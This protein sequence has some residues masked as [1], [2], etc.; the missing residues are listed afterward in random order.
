[1]TSMVHHR[2]FAFGILLALA[3]AFIPAPRSQA[4]R[5]TFKEYVD[6]LGNLSVKSLYQDRAGFLWV[7]TQGGLFRYDGSRFDEFGPAQGFTAPMVED[8]REDA[9]GR[10]WVASPNG[11]FVG[12]AGHF[13]PVLQQGKP[14]SIRVGSRIAALPDGSVLV[15]SDRGLF[16]PILPS[17]TKTWQLRPALPASIAD[18]D[19][20]RTFGLTVTPAGAIW[21][22]C[23]TS[24]CRYNNGSLKKWAEKDGLAK[25]PWE[26]L[27]VDHS[28]Q[29]WA[30]GRSHIAVFNPASNRFEPRDI[31]NASQNLDYRTLAL[32]AQ[33]RVLAPSSDALARFEN[34]Q[35]RIF[36]EK[37]GLSG[38]MLTAAF[39]DRE[40]S[41]W[42]GVLGRGLARWLGYGQWEHWTKAE[43]LKSNI[44]WRVA[45]DQT[46]R[47][48]IGDEKGVS[49]IDPGS[50]EAHPWNGPA[51]S[52]STVASIAVS[53]DGYVWLGF[54]N[55]YVLRVD[56]KT[57]QVQQFL[58]GD[59]SQIMV[60]SHDRVWTATLS[61]LFVSD[62]ATSTNPRT[63]F[64]KVQAPALPSGGFE[65]VE[66]APD[67]RIWV[68]CDDRLV[69]L[70]PEGWTRVELDWKELATRTLL[71]ATPD[72]QGNLWL[73]GYFSGVVRLQL[74]GAKIVQQ[75]HLL[76][77]TI[78]SD[79]YCLIARD[80]RGW[81]WL[82]G[83]RGLDVFDGKA[84]RHFT[85]DDGLIWNDIAAKAFWADPDGSVWFGT[86]GGLSHFSAVDQVR[87]LPPPQF[88]STRLDN[89]DNPTGASVHWSGS[90]I[91]FRLA[92]LSFQNEKSVRYRYRLSGLESDW[93][94][95]TQHEVRYPQLPPGSYRFEAQSFL[96]SSSVVSPVSTFSFTVLPPWWRTNTFRISLA[97]VTLI[98]IVLIWR[99]GNR[100]LIARQNELSNLVKA[101]TR[102]LE[103]EKSELVKAKSI[104]ADQA[105]SDFLTG[106]LNRGA[107]SQLIEVEMKRARR[108]RSSL[109]VVLMDLDYFKKVNDT[110]GH[111][112]GDEVLREVARRLSA[113]LRAYDRVGRFGGEEF[114]IV[115]PGL[116]HHSPQRIHDLHR[117]TLRDPIVVGDLSLQLTCS[118]GVAHFRP[119]IATLE[120]L[121][122]LA[123]QALY[124]AKAN[125]RNRIETA[126][127][128]LRTLARIQPTQKR[129]VIPTA[130]T[131]SEAPQKRMSSRA[132]QV[133]ASTCGLGRTICLPEGGHDN[134]PG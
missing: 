72:A 121:I 128:P 124:L 59:V 118:F 129:C 80:A 36:T 25:E 46:G 86:G 6:G 61:G 95:T 108:F 15:S 30:R 87:A 83:D 101:R 82:G 73:D 37:N 20:T 38:E 103:R 43:G 9:A 35:W 105:R 117:E 127:K 65:D 68:A 113:S 24:I 120:S 74:N 89:H 111:L 51:I 57:H 70:G 18:P 3:S 23:G 122:D 11:L 100:Q 92:S 109:T 94:E 106:L 134:S 49:T 63:G 125:G 85:Q 75:T 5:Y 4:Q 107:I 132:T 53:R 88:V 81:I 16:Q 126:G 2:H 67:G 8:I 55:H 26:Y 69:T 60:D 14:I 90:T 17:D 10:L 112:V 110:H 29:L 31:P 130:R 19:A 99:W 52:K 40:G 96:S 119:E 97:I 114:L 41:V 21:F 133:A 42:I 12:T 44:V 1:M 22:G 64:N 71:D 77:P 79:R 93:I 56:I 102:E 34:G 45:R 84:W 115:M 50:A 116:S 66:Q 54:R 32:D 131:P 33:G 78:L 28:G 27:L 104:L 7:G 58:V 76:R 91:A 47:L 48:W 13:E 98:F 123:D 62:P 39:V